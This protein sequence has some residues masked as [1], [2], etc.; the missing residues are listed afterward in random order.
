M[1]MEEIRMS[2]NKF[3]NGIDTVTRFVI[4]DPKPVKSDWKKYRTK[5][6]HK[7]SKR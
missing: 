1:K 6:K 4:G 5:A 7:T 2:I 3:M